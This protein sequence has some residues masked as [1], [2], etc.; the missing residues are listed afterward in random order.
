M[1]EWRKGDW[2]NFDWQDFTWWDYAWREDDWW[3]FSWQD[4]VWREIG[5]GGRMTGGFL[6]VRALF[7]GILHGGDMLCGRM[8]GRILNWQEAGWRFFFLRMIRITAACPTWSR[9]HLL[10]VSI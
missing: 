4:L 7:G 1:L 9:D 6:P 8:T 5:S 3:D 10:V 2:R